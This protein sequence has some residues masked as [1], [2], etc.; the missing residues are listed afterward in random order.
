MTSPLPFAAH[1]SW[2]YLPATETFVYYYLS[3]FR[4]F[5]PLVL[6]VAQPQNLERFPLPPGQLFSLSPTGFSP[7][8]IYW[9]LR[10]LLL[11][12]AP[13]EDEIRRRALPLLRRHAPRLLH[14]HFGS[15]GHWAVP[16]ARQ[17]GIP[18][19]VSFYGIDVAPDPARP[20]WRQ[21]MH[22][23]FAV[24]AH[25]LVLGPVMRERLLA[26]GCPPEKITIQPVALD[27][28]RFPAL[29][30][31]QEAPNR[32]FSLLFSG[33]FVEKKGLLYTLQA[34]ELLNSRHLPPF[35]LRVIGDGPLEA[36]MRAFVQ[37]RQLQPLVHFLGPLTHRD[38][39]EELSRCD[40][41]LH[42]SVVAAN[43]DTE[44]TPTSILEA[45]ALA[46]PLVSTWHADIPNITL[47]G[48]SALL[49]PERDAPALA[50]AIES[51]LLDPLLRA[52]L[53]Q[54]GHDFVRSRHSIT[55]CLER[56]EDLYSGIC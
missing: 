22:E 2:A 17:T 24:A 51:L 54:N 35:H 48:E 28:S 20:H 45:Q 49:V 39:L 44:G 15:L 27:F 47:P 1:L 3:N 31:H 30:P 9:K 55:A 18:L 16:L 25:F 7:L 40:I 12:R 50:D 42:P 52:R 26:L 19:I 43:G 32:P 4:R 38:Y 6:S 41:F 11:G 5:R 21:E 29:Q 14:A 10:R 46:R 33:R 53:G 13:S 34:L 36:E 56:L 37:A 8:R 23:L